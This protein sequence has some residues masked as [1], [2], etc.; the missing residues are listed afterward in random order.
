MNHLICNNC[1]VKFSTKSNLNY[2]QK[3]AKYCIVSV[4]ST[5]PKETKKNNITEIKNFPCPNCDKIFISNESLLRHQKKC[6]KKPVS[7]KLKQTQTQLLSQEV[8]IKELEERLQKLESSKNIQ[9]SEIKLQDGGDVKLH[10]FHPKKQIT[11]ISNIASLNRRDK[12]PP[13]IDDGKS[14]IYCSSDG[15]IDVTT[16]C[17]AGDKAVNS[18]NRLKKTKIFLECLSRELD[19]PVDNLTKYTNR[20]TYAH[21]QV[22]INIAQ[23]ISPE[24]DVKVSKWIYQIMITGSFNFINEKTSLELDKLTKQNNMYAEKVVLL[25]KKLLQKQERINYP[26]NTIYLVSTQQR[27]KKGEYKIG[28]AKNLKNRLSVLNT[29]DEHTVY[30]YLSCKTSTEMDI[31]EKVVHNHLEPQRIDPNREWFR[32]SVKFFTDAIELCAKKNGYI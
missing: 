19:I 21:P 10:S 3:T 24:F 29:S 26:P 6:L 11:V 16:L 31:L 5:V 4:K 12:V 23:W 8:Y 25:E 14:L 28:K 9:H 17:K 18:W 7:L 20:R 22:A 13:G 15:Y 2:H 32:G 1:G 27:D 30:F